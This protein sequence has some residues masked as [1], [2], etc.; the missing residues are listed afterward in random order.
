MGKKD[1]K[2]SILG[3][4]GWGTTLALLLSGKGFCPMLWG[5]FPDYVEE[6][7]KKRE[8]VKFLPGFKIPESVALEADLGRAVRGAEWVVLAVPSQHMRAVLRRVGKSALA[9]KNFISVAKGVET[10]TLHVMSAVVREELG[11]VPLGVLSGPTIAREVAL[12]M[13]A[14][15]SVASAHK[16]LR[17]RAREIFA[18]PYFSLYESDDVLGVEL[19]GALKNVIAISAGIVEGLGFGS[20]TRAALFARGVAEMARLGKRMGAKRETFMG[21]SGLGDLATTCLSPLSRNRRLGE[22]IGKGRGLKD[23]LKSSEMVVEGVDT[24][25]SAVALAR[26]H[27]VRMPI[28]E[29]VHGIL[30]RGR[31]PRAAVDALMKREFHHELD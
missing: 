12:E 19:G 25:R 30:F 20:N 8:N 22:E 7:R 16:T 5:A 29:A 31:D 2:I 28:T 3:D 18:T 14:A 9:G 15:V 26:R 1:T 4:G 27:R 6:V 21:L 23:I 17:A 13:P 11:A 10:G 24:S